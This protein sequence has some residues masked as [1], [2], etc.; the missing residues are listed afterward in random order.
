MSPG[1]VWR[2]RSRPDS[3]VS[4]DD[5]DRVEKHAIIDRHG[6]AEPRVTRAE[7]RKAMKRGR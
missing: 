3:I 6:S 5:L 4:L 2:R 7:W 1:T